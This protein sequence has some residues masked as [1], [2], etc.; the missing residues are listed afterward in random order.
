MN[1]QTLLIL[2][3][4]LQAPSALAIDQAITEKLQAALPE[5]AQS[6]P[7][8]DISQALIQNSQ[9]INPGSIRPKVNNDSSKIN[10]LLG[11]WLVA[12]QIGSVTY[13]DK[14]VL[15]SV[16]T[17]SDGEIMAK[18]TV[19]MDYS[20]LG[21][22]NST[23]M[24]MLCSYNPGS[25]AVVNSDYSCLTKST[26]GFYHQYTFKYAGNSITNGYYALGLTAESLATRLLNKLT[27]LR[28]TRINA[29]SNATPP[30]EDNYDATLGELTLPKVKANNG[31][32]RAKLKTTDG[33]HF[34]LL[35]VTKNP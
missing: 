22:N 16:Y 27:P 8:T 28:G 14:I 29:N 35:E 10:G 1:K 7:L 5:H 13:N 17:A 21:I 4:T 25:Y 23:G 19:Y 9:R 30:E 15:D 3:I 26:S 31:Y 12:Y 20:A 24:F 18:G 34:T 6:A 2:T 11:T 32:Y 33:Q